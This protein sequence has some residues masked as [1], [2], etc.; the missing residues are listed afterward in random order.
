VRNLASITIS[1]NPALLGRIRAEY[2][3]MP[4]LRLTARQA[5]CLFGLDSKTC[6]AVLAALEEAHFLTR[7]K[8]GLFARTGIQA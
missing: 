5:Q 2:M 3:E 4:G 6:I 7:T 8:S 1:D